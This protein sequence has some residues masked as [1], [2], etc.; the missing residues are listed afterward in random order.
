MNLTPSFD[1]HVEFRSSTSL[2]SVLIH[3][4]NADIISFDVLPD[5][6]VLPQSITVFENDPA[7]PCREDNGA[8]NFGKVSI[9]LDKGFL[10]RIL[11]KVKVA[12]NGVCVFYCHIMKAHQD[13]QPA[14]G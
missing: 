3:I 1:N 8:V 14:H 6:L 10:C 12:K 13:R 9:R 11:N 7:K 2:P 5:L 4:K